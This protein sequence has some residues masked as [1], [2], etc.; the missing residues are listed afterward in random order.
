MADLQTLTDAFVEFERR[1]DALPSSRSSGEPAGRR[2]S[3]HRS[4]PML[5]VATVVAVLAVAAGAL[6]IARNT[7]RSDRT[8]PP[9]QSQGVAA[10]PGPSTS[11]STPAPFSIPRTP[12]ELARRFRVV[13]GDSATFTVT[14]TG[15][16]VAA[17][18]PAATRSPGAPSVPVATAEPTREPH[19]AAIVGVL[20][21]AGRAGGFDLQIFRESPNQPASCDDPDRSR[22]TV[23]R[24]ADG[25]SLAVGDEPLQGSENGVTYQ[26]NLIRS[27]GVEFLMHLSNE[28]DPKGASPVLAASPPMTK[29]QLTALVTSDRW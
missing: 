27:D 17:R 26:V 15:A 16:P 22:C 6:G 21:A 7:D 10:G 2:H 12:A 13:L 18:V 24:L 5:L 3:Q 29:A 28:R 1:A 11:A 14:E 9:M 23:R 25:S 19:G 4:R 8:G 20:T